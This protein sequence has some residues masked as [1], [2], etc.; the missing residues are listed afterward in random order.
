MTAVV[1]PLRRNRDVLLLQAGRCC[2]VLAPS[3]A[4]RHPRSSSP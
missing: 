1:V 3:R 4:G 2:R